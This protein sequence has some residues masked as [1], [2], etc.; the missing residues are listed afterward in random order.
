MKGVIAAIENAWAEALT[1][2]GKDLTFTTIEPGR[3]QVDSGDFAM[4]RVDHEVKGLAG[5]V[6]HTL[7]EAGAAEMEDQFLQLRIRDLNRKPRPD[8][9]AL[10]DGQVWKVRRVFTHGPIVECVIGRT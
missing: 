1:V 9:E 7:I 10:I 2:N 4:H 3:Y 5:P 8:D 6:S